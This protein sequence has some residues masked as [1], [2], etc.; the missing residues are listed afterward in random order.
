[1]A[2]VPRSTLG[3]AVEQGLHQVM[4]SL[5]HDPVAADA[6]RAIHASTELWEECYR[7]EDIDPERSSWAVPT[8]FVDRLQTDMK[9]RVEQDMRIADFYVLPL[10]LYG[11]DGS[12]VALDFDTTSPPWLPEAEQ[13][14]HLF[15]LLKQR[16]LALWKIPLIWLRS[17]PLAKLEE[18]GPS[19]KAALRRALIPE[20]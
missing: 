19:L 18:E 10:M 17:C 7:P 6:L 15:Q 11:P 8:A 9:L 12:C 3:E 20:P 4:L 1:V 16:H 14:R 5:L 2:K 13:P